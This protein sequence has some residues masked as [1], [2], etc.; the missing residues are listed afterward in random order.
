MRNLHMS[1]KSRDGEVFT[2]TGPK[3]IREAGGLTVVH[4]FFDERARFEKQVEIWA[5][6]SD[7]VKENVRVVLVD[8]CSSSPVHTW[9]TES[10]LK[11]LSGLRF[12]IYRIKTDLQYNTPGSLNLAF[13]VAPTEFVLTMDSDCAFDSENIA[14]FLDATPRTDVVY[15]FRRQR[16]GASKPRGKNGFGRMGH[17]RLDITRYLPCS[18]LMH[19]EVFWNIGGF[20]E[21]FTGANSGGYGFFDNFFD[22]VRSSL[23]YGWY[24]W[25]DVTALEWMPSA[26]DNEVVQ[27][28]QESHNIN[29]RLYNKKLDVLETGA[30]SNGQILRFEWERVYRQ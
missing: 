23:N 19:K 11:K 29:K 28:N 8:D 27:R 30:Y 1:G 4:P 5:N 16:L 18:M 22:R 26:C 14:K 7:D 13:T 6:W 20:D 2:H 15:K 3:T 12:T 21:D 17:E 25:T 9:L 10:V 24:V